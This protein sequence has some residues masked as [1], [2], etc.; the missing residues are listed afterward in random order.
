MQPVSVGKGGRCLNSEAARGRGIPRIRLVFGTGSP[1]PPLSVGEVYIQSRWIVIVPTPKEY[2]H[3]AEECLALAGEAT[4]LYAKAALLE[5]AAEFREK[6]EGLEH[7]TGRGTKLNQRRSDMDRAH[8]VEKRQTQGTL[9]F[10]ENKLRA[11]RC[12]Q[13]RSPMTI[14]LCEPDFADSIVAT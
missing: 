2:R 3:Q 11:P 13:C 6:A 8:A 10:R 7:T 1:P 4:E 12:A 9:S 5:L 14:A